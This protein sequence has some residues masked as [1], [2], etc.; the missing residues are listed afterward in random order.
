MPKN[1]LL[2]LLA[3]TFLFSCKSSK[4]IESV[5]IRNEE[6]IKRLENTGIP[7]NRVIAFTGVAERTPGFN[8]TLHNKCVFTIPGVLGNLDKSGEARGVE[9]YA[10]LVQNEADILTSDR[11]IEAAK[12]IQTLSP[13]T[14]SKSKYFTHVD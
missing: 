6:E 14:S 8:R 2:I 1:I 10:S 4:S 11:P 12:A 7:W 9:L 13:K 3:E 5:T